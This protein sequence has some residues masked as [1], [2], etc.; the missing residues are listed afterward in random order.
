MDVFVID[1]L[2]PADIKTAPALPA[3][4]NATG[5]VETKLSAKAAV[6][7]TSMA[8]APP[9]PALPSAGLVRIVAPVAI[10]WPPRIETGPPLPPD[11]DGSPAVER[12]VPC[13]NV[14]VPKA[15]PAA[16]MPVSAAT[17]PGPDTLVIWSRRPDAVIALAVPNSGSGC[18]LMSPPTKLTPV[19]PVTVSW[20]PSNVMALGFEPINPNSA[21]GALVNTLAFAASA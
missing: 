18:K 20:P 6:P 11:K 17:S 10:K 4:E 9:D 15:I 21:T 2:S 8:I 12:I 5:A 13:S 14:I 7:V 1:R 16:G 19:P 3:P